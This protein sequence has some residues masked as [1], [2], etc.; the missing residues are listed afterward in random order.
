LAERNVRWFCDEPELIEKFLGHD[1]P[2]HGWRIIGQ[3][4]NFVLLRR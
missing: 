2:R 3:K 1:W 4:G